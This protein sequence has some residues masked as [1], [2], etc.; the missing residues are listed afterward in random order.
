MQRRFWLPAVVTAVMVTMGTGCGDECVDL[1]DCRTDKGPPAAGKQWTCNSG[2]CEQRDI[3]QGPDAGTEEDAGTEPDAGEGD[4]GTDPDAG[5]E[6]CTSNATCGLTETCNTTTSTCEDSGFVT[7]V[8]TTSTQIQAVRDA[9]DG[10]LDPALPIEG[11]FVTFIKPAVTGSSELPGFFVQAEAQGPALFVSD[12]TA[13]AAV[14][15]GDRVSF[16]VSS[17]ATTGGLRSAATVTGT[18]VISQGH[19]VQTQSTATPAGLAVNRSADT[20]DTLVTGLDSVESELTYLTGT[21]AAAGSG[22]GAGY[23]GFQITTEGVTAGA[24]NFRLR[25]PATLATELDI[26]QGCTFT[27]NAGPIWRFDANAQ[28]SAFTASELTL[29]G[30]TAPAFESAAATSLTELVLNFSRNISAASITN[31]QEQFTFTEGLTVS[32]ARVEGKQVFLTT[33]EQTPGTNYS[34]TVAN[35]VTDLAGGV[36]AAEGST[37]AFRGF[38]TA[39]VLRIS[40]VQPNMADA[41]DLVELEVVTGG[42]TAGIILQQ[43]VNSSLVLAEFADVTVATGDIIVVHL[44]PAAGFIAETQAKNEVPQS[45]AS[46]HYDTAWDFRGKDANAITFSS[47]ILLV[48]DVAGNIQDAVPFARTTGTPPA[49]FIG[50]IQAVQAAGHWLP[51]D[52]GGAPCTT[53]S[54][55]TAAAV[56][57]DW[58]A[59]PASAGSVTRTTNT[60]RRISATDTNMKEDWAVG[61]PSWGV[62]NL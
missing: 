57:A 26:T 54:T 1:Y 15:V 51:A 41:R 3:T 37:Q 56:A 39:A 52:C 12:A 2:T 10:A 5:T 53:T 32:S 46:T 17:K 50:N 43:D 4:A 48:K 27:L 42:T 29:S 36:V 20:S 40:E 49:A 9:A 58:T 55:P 47:R 45:T 24:A 7:P 21:I 34:V 22:I 31:A 16:S 30:C 6:G 25:V 19:P 35:T 33:S 11:A 60:I 18:T 44:N 8:A 28:P 59:I 23:T 61:A 13:L 14:A 38:R 62:P